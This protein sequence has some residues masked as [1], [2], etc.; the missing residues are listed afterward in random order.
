[1]A[2]QRSST[3]DSLL[4]ARERFV[5]LWGHMGSQW[6]IPRTMAEVHALLYIYGEPM[7]TDQIMDALGVSRGSASMTLRSLIDWGLVTKVHVRGERKD[8]YRAEQDVSRLFRTILRERKK[9][10]IEPLLEELQACREL[11]DAS[12]RGASQRKLDPEAATLESHN[13]R[14]DELLAFVRVIDAVSEQLIQSS[15]EGV[16]L[17]AKFLER[18]S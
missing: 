1:M 16:D 7:H 15:G 17:A 4:A 11:T 6:G 3:R 5:S 13:A 2:A 18:A 8:H 14:V 9:R 10:E 12:A